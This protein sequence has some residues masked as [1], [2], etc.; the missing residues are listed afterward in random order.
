VF[1]DHRDLLSFLR[2]ELAKDHSSPQ[3]SS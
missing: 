2:D 3:R 1:A